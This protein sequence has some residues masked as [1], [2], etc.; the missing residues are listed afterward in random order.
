MPRRAVIDVGTNSVKV[1]LADVDDDGVRP[2]WETSVQTRLGQG[3]YESR[4]LQPGPVHAT[5]LAV[6]GFAREARAQGAVSI[7]VVATSAARDASNADDLLR[8][9]RDASGL[10]CEVISGDTEAT[11]AFVGVTTH[12]SHQGIPLLVLDV[13]GG[14]TEFILGRRNPSEPAHVAH[15]SSHPIGSVRLQERFP[16]GDPPGPG[17]LPRVR[18]W[19][20]DFLRVEVLPSLG[21]AMATWGRPRHVLG[22]GGTTAI[23]ALMEQGR[24]DFDREA[25]EATC[26]SRA[27]LEGNVE[28]LWSE[29]LATRRRRRGLPPERADVVLFGAA[30]YEAVLRVMELPSLGVST[31]GL[32]FA[33]LA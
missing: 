17:E 29:D 5:A 32:R 25:I 11:W 27:R 4:I 30:I 3:F 33:A 16:P 15:R 21:H 24:D 31:R 9:I 23:L 7:R 13:G 26:F 6:A 2:T 1:L 18:A 12:P 10:P 28:A 14:S 22:V 8:A 20:D 19:L